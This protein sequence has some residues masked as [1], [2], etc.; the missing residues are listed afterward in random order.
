MHIIQAD[1]RI[2]GILRSALHTGRHHYSWFV[3]EGAIYNGVCWSYFGLEGRA[4]TLVPS[5]AS[6]HPVRFEEF[7]KLIAEPALLFEVACQELA[8][9]DIDGGL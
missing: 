9:G 7:I 2:I 8:S 6:L 3:W 4:D 5:F 1:S